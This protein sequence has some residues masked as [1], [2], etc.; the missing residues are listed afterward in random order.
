MRPAIAGS[1]VAA[2]AVHVL[3]LFAIRMRTAAT[4]LPMAGEPGA[5]E[6]ALVAAAPAPAAAPPATPAATPEPAQPESTPEPPPVATPRPE[7]APT[8]EPTPLA[9]AA[10]A[11]SAPA[12]P[13]PK[14]HH[15]ERRHSRPPAAHAGSGAA[16]APGLAVGKANAGSREAAGA[17]PSTRASYRYNPR[18]EYPEDARRQ[19][20]EGVVVLSVE[21]ETDGHVGAISVSQSSGHPLLDRAAMEAVREWTFE[22]AREGAFAVASR[23]E[24]P[25]RFTLDR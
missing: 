9:E 6:V 20:Q 22:P 8:P 17:G 5:M 4:P 24:V 13:E 7:R 14:A 16:G 15:Q 11:I 10:P 21:V 1:F 19:R 18:P 3:L 12:T 25:V 23:V 2:V